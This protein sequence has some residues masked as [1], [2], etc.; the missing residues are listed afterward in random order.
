MK[1]YSFVRKL[2]IPLSGI[3]LFSL[4]FTACKKDDQPGTTTPVAGL[5]A[6][7]LTLDKPATGITLNG[8]NL[9]NVPLGFSNYTGAYLP[10]YTGSQVIEAVDIN[11]NSPFTSDSQNFETDKYYSSFIVGSN[12]SYKNVIVED[13]LDSLAVTTGEAYVRYINA[14]PDSGSAAPSVTIT[15][16]A[17]VMDNNASYRSVSAFSK[18]AVGDAKISVSNGS[19]IN[20]DRTINLEN[21]KVYTILLVGEPGSTN[22]DKTVQIKY[23]INGTVN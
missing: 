11:S 20:A 5:M 17:N 6:F 7:N 22:P 13:M 19:N 12:G 2:I 21:N 16:G 18:V 14:I 4:L 23:I 15:S 8:S 10:I 9:T 3:L 1:S